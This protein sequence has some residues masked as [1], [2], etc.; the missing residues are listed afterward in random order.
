[1]HIKQLTT[2]N[3]IPFQTFSVR[4]EIYGPNGRENRN[5]YFTLMF[6]FVALM[7]AVFVGV[8]V[9]KWK[10]SRSPHAQG[11]VEVDQVS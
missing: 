10:A 8:A 1:M 3:K 5:V 9:A 2:I 6:A 11:F 4:R 7:G